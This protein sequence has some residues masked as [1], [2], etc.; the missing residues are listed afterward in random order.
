M[1]KLRVFDLFLS[2]ISKYA[3]LLLLLLLITPCALTADERTEN[4][5]VF[6]V[7][8][9]SLS[10]VEEIDAVTEYV[11]EEIVE[12]ILIPGDFFLL[13]QFYGKAEVLFATE[14]GAG[15][16]PGDEL[17]AIVKEMEADGRFTDIG[18]A[19]DTLQQ[20]LGRYE[21]RDRR[22][23][24]LLITDG[25]QEAPPESKYYSPDGSFNHA[26]LENSKVIQKQ[27]WK[28]HILG[29][30]A[31]SAA[32]ELAETLS[33]T[34][35]EVDEEPSPEQIAEETRDILGSIVITAP[36]RAKAFSRGGKSSLDLKLESSGYDESKTLRIRRLLIELD[37]RELNLAEGMDLEV[38]PD[39][40]NI[41]TIPLNYDGEVPL[42][43]MEVEMRAEFG[44][45]AVFTPAIF[46]VSIA[47]PGFFARYWIYFLAALLVIL[48]VLLILFLI[49]RGVFAGKKL[50]LVVEIETEERP[51]LLTLKPQDRLYISEGISGISAATHKTGDLLATLHSEG[52]ELLMEIE[53]EDTLLG[54]AVRG[55]ILGKP[56]KF[57]DRYGKFR[58]VTISRKTG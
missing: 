24:M 54:G 23:Y 55:N 44:E 28:I 40:E 29:I 38:P 3:I 39:S 43:A 27:G 4:I 33:G 56:L 30:G 14:V 58:G 15:A 32:R 34:Y 18:N 9:K 41:Y 50:E 49:S 53:D 22:K 48:L 8:D 35:T 52:D 25:K 1:M 57:R 31:G 10:M 36:P 7:L 6:L 11:K 5:D 47:P 51:R 2:S 19:L 45:G 42:A 16:T 13:I 20:T 17:S 21:N 46:T 37:G 12:K 26:F